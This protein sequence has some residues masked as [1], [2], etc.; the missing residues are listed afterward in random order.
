MQPDSPARRLRTN[1]KFMVADVGYSGTTR[2]SDNKAMTK[3]KTFKTVSPILFS[4]TPYIQ[5]HV[6]LALYCY[7]YAFESACTLLR[8][9]GKSMR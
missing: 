7:G 5:Q 8:E 6:L 3:S 4:Q 1:P 9:F 2:I